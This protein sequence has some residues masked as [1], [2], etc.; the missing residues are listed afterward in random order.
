MNRIFTI[1]VTILLTI[2][3]VACTTG[4]TPT[5]E[6]SQGGTATAVTTPETVATATATATAVPTIA[7]PTLAAPTA[8][9]ANTPS[10]RGTAIPAPTETAAPTPTTPIRGTPE[11]LPTQ[12]YV[13]DSLGLA[14]PMTLDLLKNSE[15]LIPSAYGEAV[16]LEEGIYEDR[17]NPN[18]TL[19]VQLLEENIAYGD[20]DGDGLEDAVVPFATNTGG[21]GVFIDII[22]VSGESGMV[23][24]L[25][26]APL[27][28][29][30]IISA[31]S[32]T[33]GT[34]TVNMITAGANDPAC[35]PTLEITVL[36]TYADGILTAGEIIEN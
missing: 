34:V 28:D 33:T 12:G 10:V 23:G 29:R 5:P 13:D 2:G 20:V 35:C 4:T 22:L 11:P 14:V 26:A 18:A 8:T 24:Q 31:I 25:A 21:S 17:T 6:P 7:E 32:A 15:Y 1:S 36:Y 30:V 16:Q 19:F 9:I 3:V 27:G